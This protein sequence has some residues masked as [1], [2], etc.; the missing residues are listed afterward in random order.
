M[1]FI[2]SEKRSKNSLRL[3]LF[4]Q[5]NTQEHQKTKNI[6]ESWKICSKQPEIMTTDIRLTCLLLQNVL[7]EV[8]DTVLSSV[9]TC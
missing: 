6:L 3:N 2:G 8:D 5:E 4:N 9:N 7:V 1:S